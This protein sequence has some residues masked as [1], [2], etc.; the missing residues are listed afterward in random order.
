MTTKSSINVKFLYFPLCVEIESKKDIFNTLPRYLK[1]Y[2]NQSPPSWAVVD[3]TNTTAKGK[4]QAVKK[5]K[6][7]FLSKNKIL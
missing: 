6:S 5:E 4:S 7:H 3:N 1:T 2:L